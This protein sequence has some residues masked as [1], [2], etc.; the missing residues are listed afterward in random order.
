MEVH[1]YYGKTYK[2]TKIELYKKRKGGQ[3]ISSLSKKYQINVP[4]IKYLI[5]LIDEPPLSSRQVK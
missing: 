3:T 5:R 1:F 4:N 2:R